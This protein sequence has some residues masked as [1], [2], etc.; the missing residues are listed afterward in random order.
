MHEDPSTKS[1]HNKKH[2]DR[3]ASN[4]IVQFRHAPPSSAQLH[5]LIPYTTSTGNIGPAAAA[6]H[7]TLPK[8]AKHIS[9][10]FDKRV[11]DG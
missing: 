2:H 6:F 9:Q 10:I 5:T 4:L 8:P 7:I 11:I 1:T 3:K